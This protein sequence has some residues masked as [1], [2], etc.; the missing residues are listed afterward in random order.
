[1][2]TAARTT[3]RP[4][5]RDGEHLLL[6]GIDWTTYEKFLDAVGNRPIRLTYDGEDLE[7]T[8][9]RWDQESFSRCMNSFVVALGLVLKC[10]IRGGGS[11]TL[12]RAGV[13]RCVE[14]DQ[15]Y[16]IRNEPVAR[17]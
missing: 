1:M 2:R 8:L 4:T 16:Y 5:T 6:G 14:A 3:P 11:T 17:A 12:K 9:P 10:A 13:K 7:F 15:S